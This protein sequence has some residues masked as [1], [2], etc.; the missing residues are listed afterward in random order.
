MSFV[1]SAE[2]LMAVG[3]AVAFLIT[4][5]W[6]RRRELREKYAV[7]WIALAFILLLI[8]LFPS[9]LKTV[10]EASRLSYPAAVL[11]LAL[12]IIYLYSFS[13]SVSLSSQYRRNVRLTQ[14]MA[15]LEERVRQLESQLKHPASSSDK[16]MSS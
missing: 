11:F 2:L 14:Q 12:T 5:Y 7:G 1:L 4:L 15:L 3:G 10:A 8:G 13:V 6:V 9:V 16:A